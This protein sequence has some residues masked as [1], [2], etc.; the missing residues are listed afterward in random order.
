MSDKLLIIIP[1]F[2]EETTISNVINDLK[3]CGFKDILVV[4]DGSSDQTAYIARNLQVEVISHIVNI[5]LGGAIATGLDFARERGYEHVITFDADGQHKALDAV[6]IYRALKENYGDLIIGSR[7]LELKKRYYIRYL[8]NCLSNIFTFL[9]SGA[10]ISDSQ[11]GLRGF[12]P[13]AL[14]S[15]YPQTSGYEV[16]SEIIMIAKNLKLLVFEVPV[17]ACY[18]DYSLKKGQKISNLLKVARKLLAIS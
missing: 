17:T 4:D 2:N 7:I 5:G 8:V 12:G 13:R 10:L 14:K 15:I 3:K 9:F 1:A 16:S 11:S 6:K 18:S